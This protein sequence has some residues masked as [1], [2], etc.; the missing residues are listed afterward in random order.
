MLII[1]FHLNL[2]LEL[3]QAG[4]AMGCEGMQSY[5]ATS[6][7]KHLICFLDVLLV[8]QLCIHLVLDAM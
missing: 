4:S 3:D 5:A 1:A 6:R 8:M 2:K 7:S